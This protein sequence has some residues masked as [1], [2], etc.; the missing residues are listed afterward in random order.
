MFRLYY[1]LNNLFVRKYIKRKVYVLV[2][3]FFILKGVGG[4]NCVL[5]VRDFLVLFC[6]DFYM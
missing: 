1:E 5:Y 3:E 6:V 4:G 2:L